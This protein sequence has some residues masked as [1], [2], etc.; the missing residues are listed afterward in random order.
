MLRRK[1]PL[2][3]EPRPTPA[4]TSHGSSFLLPV[5]R[6]PLA[7]ASSSRCM[8]EGGIF[9]DA[10]AWQLKGSGGQ[11][12]GT[13]PT[14][15]PSQLQPARKV[16][17]QRT[18]AARSCKRKREAQCL[19]GLTVLQTG[20]VQ[21][22]T[23]AKYLEA[24]AKLK[25]WCRRRGYSVETPSLADAAM[26][27]YF[28]ELFMD[29]D[30]VATGRVVL[31]ALMFF[32]VEW[33]RQGNQL[34]PRARLSLK[35]WKRLAPPEARLPYPWEVVAAIA[36]HFVAK[37]L[38]E[39][40]I[41]MILMFVC[42]LRPSEAHRLRVKDVVLPLQEAGAAHRCYTLILHPYEEAVPSKTHEF[43]ETV[44]IDLPHHQWVGPSLVQIMSLRS[45][46]GDEVV[47]KITQLQFAKLLKEAVTEM[48][49]E[50]AGEPHPYRLRHG[51]ASTDYAAGDRPLV[52]IQRRGR[53][54]S[55]NSVRRYEKGGRLTQQLQ[56]LPARVRAHAVSCA[57]AIAVIMCGQR[58]PLKLR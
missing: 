45:R 15:R 55:Y 12:P 32:Q 41:L 8:T 52:D 27:A 4:A 50:G 43:D 14:H 21:Q 6:L 30:S 51:G 29:G 35:G 46:P 18:K 56:Q 37:F 48:R 49:L 13:V 26:E 7:T 47:F 40:A 34:M 36:N 39:A 5:P 44:Q 24:I 58:S 11:V 19:P 33:P 2:S 42:Y 20:T 1:A 9:R 10:V 25:F 31:A 54:R 22:G 28:D 3:L 57:E 38:F 16:C 17:R 53:W 23:R